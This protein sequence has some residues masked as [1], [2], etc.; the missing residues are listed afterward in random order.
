MSMMS[1]QQMRVELL[2]YPFQAAKCSAE[3]MLQSNT[4]SSIQVIHL[5]CGREKYLEVFEALCLCG[6][7]IMFLVTDFHK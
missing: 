5:F 4:A 1:T 7:I 3:N 2:L 6:I